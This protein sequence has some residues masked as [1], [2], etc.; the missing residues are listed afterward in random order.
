[1]RGQEHIIA[2][3]LAGKV[4]KIAFVNDYPCK[5]DWF[6]TG[7]HATVCTA[8]NALSS[9]DLRFLVGISVSISADTEA[10]AKAIFAKAKEAG[11]KTVA[12][13]HVLPG[14]APFRQ[15]G[16]CEVFHASEVPNA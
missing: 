9:L 5:T 15:A 4:P 1:M 7:D 3:R 2:M 12:A 6:E 14:V 16:W 10:R 13:C 11:A 8:G